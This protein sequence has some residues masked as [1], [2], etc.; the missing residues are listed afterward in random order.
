MRQGV[1]IKGLTEEAGLPFGIF[2]RR[3]VFIFGEGDDTKGPKFLWWYRRS[4]FGCIKDCAGVD[5][6]NSRMQE[7]GLPRC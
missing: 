7:H 1:K 3:P 2:Y 4:A 6:V 5:Q